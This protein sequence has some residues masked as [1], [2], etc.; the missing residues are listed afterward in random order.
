MAL[1]LNSFMA[2]TGKTKPLTSFWV[3]GSLSSG[4]NR[5]KR[6]ADLSP[7]PSTEVKHSYSYIYSTLCLHG[8]AMQQRDSFIAFWRDRKTAKSDYELRHVCLSVR[9]SVR[10]EQLA[11]HWTYFH[12]I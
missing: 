8:M 9:P 12:E 6:E 2:C 1:Y 7:P 4:V 10:M 5:L 11:S 3:P